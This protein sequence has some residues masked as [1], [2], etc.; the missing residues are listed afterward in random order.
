MERSIETIWKKGFLDSDK[1]V[2]PKLNDLYNQKSITIIEKLKRMMKVNVYI[3]LI[4][5]FLNLG[6]YTALGTPFAGLFILLLLI[7]VCWRSIKQDKTMKKVDTSLNS[8]EYLKAFDSWL[9]LA[10]SNNAKVMRFFYPLLFLAALMPIVHTLKDGAVTN[11]AIQDSGFQ[12]IYG[13]PTFAWVI[14]LMI[15]I[16]MYVFGGK[17]YRWDVNIVYGRIFKK[18]EMMLADMEEL[19]S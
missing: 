1:L 12:L 8:Y 19:R 9:K 7:G 10:I 6:L 13:I 5:A 17:I 3:I 4:F 14:A 18:I 2:A 11:K 15:A 16:L